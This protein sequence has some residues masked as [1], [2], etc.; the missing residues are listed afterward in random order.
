[1]KKAK[2]IIVMSLA[3]TMLLGSTLTAHAATP[4]YKPLSEYGYTGVP[5]ITVKLPDS[6]QTGI[7]N[8]V[9]DAVKDLD[10]KLLN[11]T[12]ITRATYIHS[13]VFYSKSRLNI[14]VSYTH[15]TLPTKF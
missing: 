5:N 9:E 3:T 4:Q 6:Y 1:M 13:N 8:A 14:P 10:I 11:T 2:K 15:L 7:S 12:T